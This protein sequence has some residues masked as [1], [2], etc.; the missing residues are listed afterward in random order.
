MSDPIAMQRIEL[1]QL[2]TDVAT[3]SRIANDMLTMLRRASNAVEIGNAVAGMAPALA[4][5]V[6]AIQGHQAAATFALE[7]IS[8]SAESR[9]QEAHHLRTLYSIGQAINS[10]LNL[11]DVLNLLMD[12][13]IEVTKAER[14]Y[15]VL[16]DEQSGELTVAVAR[17]IDQ[18]GIFDDSF[19]ISRGIVNGVATSGQPML[20]TN[21]QADPRFSAM[22]SVMHYNLRAILCAPLVIRGQ[23]SG[24]VYVDNRLRTGLFSPRDLDLLVNLSNQAAIAIENARLFGYMANVLASIASGVVTTDEHGTITTFNR[25]AGRIFGIPA[26]AAIGKHYTAVLGLAADSP[27]PALFTQVLDNG[28]LILGQEAEAVVPG[29]GVVVLGINAARVVGDSGERLGIVVGLED[30]TQERRMERYIAPN[31]VEH[32]LTSSSAPKLGG[33]LREISVLFGDV[34]G[35]TTLSEGMSPEELIDLLNTHLSLAGST[36]MDQAYEGT[37]DKYI[38]DA[39]MGLFNT[40]GEQPDHAWRAVGAAWAMQTRL[41]EFQQTLPP[42]R[43]LR[44][45]VG[46]HTGQAVVG[47]IGSENLMN[48]T[49]IGDAVN[50]AKRLQESARAGQ[51]VISEDTYRAIAPEQRARLDVRPLGFIALKG[52][53][54][55]VPAYEVI[56]IH[57]P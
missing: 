48:F 51:V 21:A 6:R 27:V 33:A 11:R 36:I 46:V 26:D 15:V 3:M 35:Y 44:F 50:V 32:L 37:L 5:S 17:G 19:N 8:R 18:A 53:A 45:R 24:V 25:A 34:Q 4:E 54:A 42:E 47:H 49:A 16:R 40:P 57:E 7:A 52:R 10:S 41:R 1:Q 56:G 9:R 38:G 28:D 2:E 12:K 29:R 14:G 13:V 23:V 31:V 43:H 39:V 20:T 55:E 30:R 22:E